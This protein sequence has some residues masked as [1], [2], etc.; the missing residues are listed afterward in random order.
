MFFGL[1]AFVL[2]LYFFAGFGKIVTILRGVN[3]GQYAFF[4]ALAIAAMLLTNFFWVLSWRKLLNSLSVKISVKNAFMYYWTGYFIDLVVPCE[5]VCGEV[6]RLVLV[7]KETDDNYGFIAA[8][9]V[10][11][12]II[13][14]I[15]V[16]SG[17]YVSTV[18]LFLKSAIPPVVLG[19]FIFILIGAS[20]YLAFLL[21]LAFSK[22]AADRIAEIGLSVM[23]VLRPKKYRS[24][25]LSPEVRRSLAAFYTGFKTFREKP[26]LLT[27]PILYLTISWLFGLSQYVLVFFALGIYKEAFVFFIIIYFLAGS[28][29]DAAASFS[30]GTLEIVLASIF[31]LYGLSP[32]LSGITAALV[33]SVTFW[34]P[35]IMGYIVVQVFGAKR[36]LAPRPTKKTD[37]PASNR[38]DKPSPT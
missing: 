8:G 33:R 9:G 15:I 14:Y 7:Q 11:N 13:A 4:Y 10:T 22:H 31:I 28:L 35:L 20:V 30:V 19:V 18:L 21:Y 27:K 12:R 6:T 29:T 5:T 38:T 23:K 34:S 26:K 17:L 32:A 36:L 16:V 3:P 37:I 24:T 1:A 2:Y 25:D